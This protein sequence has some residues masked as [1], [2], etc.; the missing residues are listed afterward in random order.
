LFVPGDDDKK[1]AKALSSEADALIVDLE[2]SVARPA[3]AAARATAGDGSFN[4]GRN[5]GT[6]RISPICA[7][8]PARAIFTSGSRSSG[9]CAIMASSA[10]L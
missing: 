6:A 1:L 5:N 10:P 8:A 9:S 7:S 2:D 4:S 3:K